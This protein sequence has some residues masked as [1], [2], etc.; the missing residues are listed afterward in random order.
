MTEKINEGIQN[1]YNTGDLVEYLKNK[2]LLLWWETKND[3][4]RF[5]NETTYFNK[6]KNESQIDKFRKKLFIELENLPKDK[7]DGK[8]WYNNILS[9]IKNIEFSILGHENSSID[10]FADKGYSLVTEAFLDEARNF[11]SN[12]EIYDI[13]QAIRNVWIMNSIQI[14][15][16]IEVELTPSIFAYSMLYPYTD[17]YLD[18]TMVSLEDKINF[19]QRFKEWLLGKEVM[20]INSHEESIYRLVKNIE[21]QYSRDQNSEVFKSLLYIHRAQEQSLIQQKGYTLPF[22]KDIIGISFEKGGTS[23]LADGYLVKGQLSEEESGFMFAYGVFLQLIDDLQDVKDDLVNNHMTIFSS[24]AKKL[25]LDKLTNKLFWF[26]EE[27]LNDTDT[28]SSEESIKVKE[29]IRDSCKI[30]ILEAISKNKNMFSKEYVKKIEKYSMVRFSYY[31]KLKNKFQKDFSP[32]DFS[33]ICIIL[34]KNL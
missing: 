13:F 31:K 4:P 34:G 22:E 25:P 15:F 1:C 3:F 28:F 23:V 33:N 8:E 9:L 6:L 30:M 21:E 19:N 24:L 10:F 26:I 2:Y 7:D 17:N 11:D 5:E 16:D 29:V 20:P 12:I 27:V 18:N 14:L 32:D